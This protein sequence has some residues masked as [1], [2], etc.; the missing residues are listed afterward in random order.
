DFCNRAPPPPPAW[1]VYARARYLRDN[2][3]G[4][5]APPLDSASSPAPMPV[6]MASA[7]RPLPVRLQAIG[8]PAGDDR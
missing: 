6:G 2:P 7:E 5:G 8:A 4:A 1:D 3:D